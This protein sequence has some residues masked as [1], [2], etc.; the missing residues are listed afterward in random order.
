MKKMKKV[1][2]KTNTM[3]QAIKQGITQKEYICC[4]FTHP[5]YLSVQML[6]LTH[7]QRACTH[8]KERKC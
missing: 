3:K 7:A 4:M 5:M 2:N 8:R 6:A 1:V